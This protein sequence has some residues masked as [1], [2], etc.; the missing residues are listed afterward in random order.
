MVEADPHKQPTSVEAALDLMRRRARHIGNDS[1]S[2]VEKQ[3]MMDAV[4]SLDQ[5]WNHQAAS[6]GYREFTQ[7][8]I[9]RPSGIFDEHG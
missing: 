5:R 6:W 3:L 7:Q 1:G 9:R 4:A 8:C 2:H